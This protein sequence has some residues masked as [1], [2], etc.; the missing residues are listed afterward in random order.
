MG[1]QNACDSQG[2]ISKG[3]GRKSVSIGPR[4]P[5]VGGVNSAVLG[6]GDRGLSVGGRKKKLSMD[7]K[8]QI[9]IML[10]PSILFL[11]ISDSI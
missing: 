5:S 11:V 9:K 2:V 10:M 4:K 7:G 6:L 8:G 3:F 1:C